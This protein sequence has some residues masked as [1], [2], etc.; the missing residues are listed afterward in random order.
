MTNPTHRYI[1]P[2]TNDGLPHG[3]PCRILRKAAGEGGRIIET[4]RVNGETKW[5]VGRSQLL[6]IEDTGDEP[7][8]RAAP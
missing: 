3:T 4:D 8:E 2:D 6:K 5:L 1:G 7:K